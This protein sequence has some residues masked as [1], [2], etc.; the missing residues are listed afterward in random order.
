MLYV[1]LMVT[2]REK[3]VVITQKYIVKKSNILTKDIKTQK[4]IAR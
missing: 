1:S 4:K 3:P 2:T